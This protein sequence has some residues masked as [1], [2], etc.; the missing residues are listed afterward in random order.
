MRAAAQPQA[1][2]TT[3]ATL[4]HS[5]DWVGS[6]TS[7]SA[8]AAPSSATATVTRTL[9]CRRRPGRATEEAGGAD[10]EAL[11]MGSG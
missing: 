7:T 2:A 5:G 1:S 3:E 8:V 11:A 10:G 9:R 4:S 6:A